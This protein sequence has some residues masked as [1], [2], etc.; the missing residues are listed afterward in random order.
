MAVL[1]VITNIQ[2]GRARIYEFKKR[3]GRQ[4]LVWSYKAHAINPIS[5]QSFDFAVTR[6]VSDMVFGKVA[7]QPGEGGR[8]PPNV[9]GHPYLG[10][11]R[12]DANVGWCIQLFDTDSLLQECLQGTGLVRR[13]HILIHFGPA[14]SEG[15][16][17]VAGGRR[18]WN[19]F[20][21]SFRLLLENNP[22]SPIQIIVRSL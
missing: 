21:K 2:A 20:K 1:I 17:M 19:K 14:R 6:D 16:F 4:K 7:D 12:T 18:G 11:V 9:P 22:T 10:R 8:C 13:K 3:Q 15:C 5:G